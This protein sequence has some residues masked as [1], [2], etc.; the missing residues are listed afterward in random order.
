MAAPRRF[1]RFWP[2]IAIGA[3]MLAEFLLFDRMT[4]RH[5]AS[6][7]PRWADQIQ[8]LI[9]A[10][11]AHDEAQAHGFF[12]GLKFALTNPAVQGTMHDVGAVVVFA[13][14]GSASRSA[15]LSLNMLVF[16]AW[17][18]AL[19][20]SLRRVTGS[21]LVGWTG[22]GLVLCLAWPWSA[23]AGSAVDFR[24]DHA[25]M[26]LFGITG[27]LA[28]CSDGFR[29]RGWSLALGVGLA[30]TL[31]TR[32]LTAVYFV[33][34]FVAT[35]VWIACGAD[36][37]PRLRNLFLSAFVA[38]LFTAPVFWIN[39]QGILDYYWVGHVTGSE[40][41]ART[42][43]LN[44]AQSLAF[45]REHL[46]YRHLGGWFCWTVAGVTTAFIAARFALGRRAA[47]REGRDWLFVALSF[48]LSPAVVLTL[49]RQK[50]DVVLGIIAPG[51]VLF[52]LWAWDRLSVRTAVA[53]SGWRG[54]LTVLPAIGALVS[55]GV[56]FVRSEVTPPHTAEFLR[57][58]RQLN[59]LADYIY[60][61]SRAAGLANPNV[62]IDRIVDFIDGRIL[63]VICYERHRTWVPFG[64]HLPDSILTQ[65]DDVVLFKLKYCDFMFLT[66]RDSDGGFW[67]YDLQMRRLYP[68]L[69]GWCDESLF[70]V[71][72]VE[73]FGRKM[74]FYARKQ[75][76][77]N[78]P[79]P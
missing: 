71:E 73:L 45:L 2:W 36:R 16:L 54:G 58:A 39:R 75:L 40:G 69:K 29:H 1:L 17:Q 53:P 55:G 48:A 12:S 31:L 64:V 19:W 57:S 34:V 6:L 63:R 5:H 78:P 18:L 46:L 28:L 9:E 33:P 77:P 10:Y 59:T 14:S 27:C 68:Q 32:F 51:I 3:L 56:F 44:I 49:H 74:K 8:Y 30:L 66:S 70:A 21:S 26:C 24:L 50:S 25:A 42:P 35:L 65:P 47:T 38:A 22:F 60:D 23:G 43:G 62:G 72:E 37:G 13:L 41:A 7:Y 15:A 61:R 52:V 20:F 67:P 11:E 4:S 76:L 79:R